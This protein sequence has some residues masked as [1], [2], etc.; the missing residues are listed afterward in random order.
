MRGIHDGSNE[1]EKT[2]EEKFN[3]L[4]S[5]IDCQRELIKKYHSKDV[6][7]VP[8]VFIP[9]KEVLEIYEQGL[10]VPDEVKLMWCDDN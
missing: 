4:Q 8:Q 10:R 6:E 7:K 1:G 9:Y 3:G 2:R 5:V